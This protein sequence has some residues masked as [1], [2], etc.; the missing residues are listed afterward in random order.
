M[1]VSRHY[2]LLG[3]VAKRIYPVTS[4]EKKCRNERAAMEKVRMRVSK[5]VERHLYIDN[6]LVIRIK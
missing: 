1:R 6:G 2:D 3:R 5:R 4:G